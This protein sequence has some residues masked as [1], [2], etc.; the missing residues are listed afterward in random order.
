MIRAPLTAAL[1][2]MGLVPI[3]AAQ[4]PGDT[5]KLAEIV[6]TATR[7]PTPADSVAA[8]VS[9]IRGDD[10]RA[11]GIHFV[12]DALREVPGAQVVQN[13]PY[14]AATSLFVRGGERHYGKAPV[15]PVPGER[16]GGFFDLGGPPTRERGRRR[17]L[18]APATALRVVGAP[19]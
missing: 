9:V 17:G 10:L 2:C 7:Y 3:L 12:S 14:G 5:T 4:E 1:A 19:P 6:V 11:R 15:D 13:G 8:T 18:R 16:P